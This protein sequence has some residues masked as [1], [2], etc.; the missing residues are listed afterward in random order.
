MFFKMS[1]SF[2]ELKHLGIIWLE[3]D[4]LAYNVEDVEFIKMKA[5]NRGLKVFEMIKEEEANF[6]DYSFN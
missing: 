2:E 1:K 3:D 6:A 4:N 5:I